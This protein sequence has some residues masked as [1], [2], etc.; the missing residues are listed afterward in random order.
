MTTIKIKQDDTQPALKVIL[1]DS[2]GNPAN[3]TG[4]TVQVAIQHYS[5]PDI[6]FLRDAYIADAVAGEVW[7]VW[8]PEET[9]VTG[10]YRIEFRVTY[11]DGN[12][13]TFPNDGYLLVNILE[14][15]GV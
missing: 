10:L 4:A 7:L 6:K 11:Q 8:Q 13:E 3:L 2:A 15:I 5:Q 1:K 12:R 9:Q 14:R